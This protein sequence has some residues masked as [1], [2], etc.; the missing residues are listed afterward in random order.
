[1]R[2]IGW[3]RVSLRAILGLALWATTGAAVEVRLVYVGLATGTV[4]SGVEQGLQEANVLGGFT[5]QTYS[6]QT[7]PPET[8]LAAEGG[9]PPLAVV[10]ATDATTLLR[11]SAK[12]AAASV[13]VL[14]L[15]SDDDALRQLCLPNLLHVPPSAQMKADAVAQW[16]K[17]K[18]N[19][20]VLARTW[21]EDFTKF[22]ARE[23]N[24]RFR[25]AR[26]MPMDDDAWAGWAALKM[27]SEAVAR[28]QTTEPARI[29]TYLRTELGFDGQKG[30]PQTFRETGQ[31]RQPVL[32]VE[33]GKL[34]GEAP[35]PGVADGSNLDSL[36]MTSCKR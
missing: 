34:V 21:H 3:G 33:D 22:A 12:V 4:W 36:G 7:V 30:V 20:N 14:N 2:R 18:P 9:T 15:T 16:Q 13:A 35:V 27:L 32:L 31:M 10:A 26:G 11:L 25:K 23:L 19:A 29:L 1:M 5:G 17:K 28:L 8:F 6:I 24:N